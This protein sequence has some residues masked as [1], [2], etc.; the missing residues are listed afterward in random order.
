MKVLRMN[1]ISIS[2]CN[3][4]RENRKINI[5]NQNAEQKKKNNRNETEQHYCQ[6][7]RAINTEFTQRL[8]F[9]KN[10]TVVF[11][12]CLCHPGC[13]NNNEK[14]QKKTNIRTE[15]VFDKMPGIGIRRT[16]KISGFFKE[17]MSN[18]H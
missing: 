13:S 1:K 7:F 8:G 17:N 5:R 6:K 12:I 3:F 4:S 15:S 14:K 11:M 10:P 2:K 9:H 18:E 16:F